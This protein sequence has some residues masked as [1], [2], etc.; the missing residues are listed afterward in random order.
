MYLNRSK[1]V[2]KCSFVAFVLLLLIILFDDVFNLFTSS[3]QE[4]VKERMVDEQRQVVKK[5]PT[6]P[7]AVTEN[8][9]MSEASAIMLWWTPFIGE[10]EYTKD[11]GNA[12]CF[13]T[14]NHHYI[15]HEKLKD[16]E[17]LYFP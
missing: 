16:D 13:F 14:G 2:Q 3:D 4:H 1:V 12:V 15:G 11:C 8:S 7:S 6:I 9:E 10:M 5:I 17:I